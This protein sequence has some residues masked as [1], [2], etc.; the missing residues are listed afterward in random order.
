LASLRPWRWRWYCALKH[1]I[2]SELH[3]VIKQKILRFIIDLRSSIRQ[4]N[5]SICGPLYYIKHDTCFKAGSC[6]L[7]ASPSS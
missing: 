7:F 5:P 2:L 6:Y 4:K 1:W 3:D